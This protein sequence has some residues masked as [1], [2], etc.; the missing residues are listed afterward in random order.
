MIEPKQHYI[1]SL[2]FTLML[3]NTLDTHAQ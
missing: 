3:Q 2:N 1:C